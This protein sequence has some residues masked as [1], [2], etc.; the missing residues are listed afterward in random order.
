MRLLIKFSKIL[1]KVTLSN[2]IESYKNI[3]SLV[4][5]KT[6][7]NFDFYDIIYDLEERV[8]ITNMSIK[9]NY[10]YLWRGHFKP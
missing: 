8:G 4:L 9:Y 1:V 3:I 10:I 6:R 7:R 5:T 2:I